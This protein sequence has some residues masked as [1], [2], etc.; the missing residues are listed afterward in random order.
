M[1]KITEINGETL[2]L[3]N[4]SFRDYLVEALK[5]RGAENEDI[6]GIQD[7]I[8][9]LKNKENYIVT[10]ENKEV[11][12][13]VKEDK[14]YEKVWEDFWKDIVC[15][16]DGS[17]NI[18]QVKKELSDFHFILE[19]IPK[20]YCHITNGTLSKPNYKAE[21]VIDVFESTQSELINKEMAKDD[22]LQMLDGEISEES[23]KELEEYFS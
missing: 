16:E 7:S 3:D 18:E 1:Y 20:V 10:F 23:K 9:T 19:Q 17:I 6:Q 5:S 11:C 21:T 12:T 22:L 15:N 4:E 2:N 13:L 8:S 14:E